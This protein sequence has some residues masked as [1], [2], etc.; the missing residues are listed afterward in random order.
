MSLGTIRNVLTTLP[1][2]IE[3]LYGVASELSAH[4]QSSCLY[5]IGKSLIN[6]K[7]PRPTH[8]YCAYNEVKSLAQIIQSEGPELRKKITKIDEKTEDARVSLALRSAPN[9]E[10]YLQILAQDGV[11]RNWK[12]GSSLPRSTHFDCPQFQVKRVLE[13]PEGLKVMSIVSDNEALFIVRG[14]DPSNIHNVADDLAKAIAKLNSKKYAKELED[15]LV[16]LNAEYGRVHILGHSYGGAVSQRLTSKHP[17]L[18]IRCTSYNSPG[19]GE[20]VAKLFQTKIA[21]LPRALEKPHIRSYRHAKDIVSLLGGAQLPTDKAYTLGTTQD[22]ISRLGAH[23]I[24]TL[25]TT[26]P[27]VENAPIPASMQRTANAIEQLRL[28][29]SQ[30]IPFYKALKSA[31]E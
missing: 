3:G 12:S 4:V 20:K 5:N 22:T 7:M 17:E 1:A 19:V 6:L 18:I 30:A 9:K 2:A 24:N 23:Y 11:Y 26:A 25:S 27:I 16:E 10:A 14:T 21:Q 29:L 8:L 28:K 31:G 15:H 13:F